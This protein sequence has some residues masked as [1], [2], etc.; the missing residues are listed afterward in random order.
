MALE[1]GTFI[2][3]LVD[4]NPPGTDPKKEGDDHLRLIKSILKGTF[5]DAPRAFH[6]PNAPAAKTGNYTVVL[7]DQNALITVDASGAVRTVTLP[8]FASV[9]AG[10]S[11]TIQKSDTSV[12]TVTVD[13]N[14]AET[15]NGDANK[16]LRR[17]HESMTV[18]SDGSDWKVRSRGFDETEL[19]EG[20]NV[21][22]A[23]SPNI[24]E[25]DGDTHHIT[26][27]TTITGY[28]AAPQAGARRWLIM[29]DA[30]QF[31]D[32]ATLNIQGDANYTSVLDDIIEVY[33]E[34]TT[35]FKLVIHKKDGT[36]V[37]SGA[38]GDVTGPGSATNRT[39]ALFDGTT[40]KLIKNGP[41]SL[42]S[43]NVLTANGTGADPTF[44]APA[45]GP[46]Q[47]TKA[48][49]EAETD[50]NTYA[51]PDLLK[52]SPGVAKAWVIISDIGG[53]V[54]DYNV[55]SVG[56]D[57]TGDWAINLTTAFSSATYAVVGG[58]RMSGVAVSRTLAIDDQLA[59]SFGLRMFNE[60]PADAD[61]DSGG[62]AYAIAFGDQ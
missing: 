3:D 28:A 55:T 50:Q 6:F 38:G 33:A 15:I 51:P 8:T 35:V 42:T 58:H 7:T 61:P 26:G 17:P 31:T 49:I 12:N 60:T 29:D 27:T 39:V 10:F 21:A 59:G 4:T 24:W 5:P 37:V 47:A 25:G 9:F 16:V 30:V 44:Q 36:P 19:I 40:G 20:A 56:D 57:G 32:S 53:L 2:D 54:A 43:G 45:G 52:H 14:G 22:S 1:T 11:V 34:T 23:A 48:A 41:T 13:G 62:Q 18:T 46:S